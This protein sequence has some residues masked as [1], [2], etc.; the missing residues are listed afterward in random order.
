[1]EYNVMYRKKDKGWQFI[2]QYKLNKKWKQKSKQ[3]FESKREAKFAAE[4]MVENLKRDLK[5]QINSSNNFKDIT[6]KEFLDMYLK[7]QIYYQTAASLEN[8]KYSAASFKDLYDMRIKDIKSINIQECID[9]LMERNL[10]YN[11]IKS[12]VSYVRLLFNTAIKKYKII[13]INP[14]D[15]VRFAKDKSPTERKA[16]TMAEEQNLL[17]SLK[18]TRYYLVALIAL[19]AGLRIGEILGLKYSDINYKDNTLTVARQFKKMHNGTWGLGELKSANSYRTI[20]IQVELVEKINA[21][22]FLND[23][24]EDDLIFNFGDKKSFQTIM[25]KRFKDLGFN[26]CLHELRHTYA[27]K[28]VKSGLDLKTVAYL[29]GHTIK[30]TIEVYSHVNND[31][32]NI[33]KDII[34]NI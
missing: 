6:F 7:N 24:N 31:M 33:A 3:G 10:K 32:L 22:R 26:I 21:N 14:A 29:L 23:S 34:K 18:G 19:K 17:E 27:T 20:P 9:K 28:L 15:D 11:T 4:K 12:K 5:H 25:N 30:M 1:M 13:I 2:I 8:M 16:L